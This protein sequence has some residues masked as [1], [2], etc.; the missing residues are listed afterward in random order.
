MAA[1]PSETPVTVATPQLS[2]KGSPYDAASSKSNSNSNDNNEKSAVVVNSQYGLD[3]A[4]SGTV[5]DVFDVKQFDPVLARK[6]ALVNKAIDEIG[7]TGFQWKLFWLNGFGYTVD[8]V[9]NSI[10]FLVVPKTL[11]A[12]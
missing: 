10:F 11:V 2:E 5:S 1:E 7:M 6:M 8:S 9:C 3:D 4:S 12:S